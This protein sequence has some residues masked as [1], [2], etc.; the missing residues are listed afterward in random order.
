MSLITK[1]AMFAR[2]PQGQRLIAKASSY[3]QS[4][5]GRRRIAQVREQVAAR[6]RGKRAR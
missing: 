2:S 5:E 1:V 6:G 4:P 3:A